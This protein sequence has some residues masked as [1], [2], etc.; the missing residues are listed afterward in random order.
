[1][2]TRTNH[3]WPFQFMRPGDIAVFSGGTVGGIRERVYLNTYRKGH[4]YQILPAEGL[5]IARRLNDDGTD[6]GRPRGALKLTM[7]LKSAPRSYLQEWKDKADARALKYPLPI[8]AVRTPEP[9]IKP[10]GWW[11]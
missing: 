1:M 4:Q 6:P 7:D 3:V 2:A 8:P 10:L 9:V 11:D 5:V